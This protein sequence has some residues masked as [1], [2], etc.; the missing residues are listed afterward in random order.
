MAKKEG[1]TDRQVRH[2]KAGTKRMEV[3]AGP[4][5]GLYL[6]VHPTGRKSWM[7]RYRFRGR[8]RGLTLRE[9]YPDMSLAQARAEAQA[10]LAKLQEDIDPAA[11]HAEEA[12]QEKPDSAVAVAEEWLKRYVRPNT[13]WDEA[14]RILNRDVLPAWKD[15]LITEIGRADVLRLLD[16]IV[17]RG[18]PIVANRTFEVIRSW[19][20]WCVRRGILETSSLAGVRPPTVEKSRD[21]VLK[22]EELALV[23]SAAPD[24]DFPFGP[25]IRL[26]I[27]TAQRRGEVGQMRW[28]DVDM[29]HAMWTL[30]AEATKPGR[31]HDVPLPAVAM[32]LLEGL[33]RFENGPFIFTT[34]GGA[35]P[36]SG[37][38]KAK[39]R[40][41]AKIINGSKESLAGWTLH[42]LR[43]TAATHMAAA[44]VP[45]HVLSALL[46]HSAGSTQGVLSIYNRFRYTEERR[47]A[48]EAWGEY[49]T[50]LT[51]GRKRRAG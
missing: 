48:L 22:P 38:S 2:M 10:A 11:V 30:P 33:P 49:V 47:K 6:V 29:D 19:F 5:S 31:V 41:D 7:F 39:L 26:L 51:A 3:P 45:P 23:W 9:P 40:L 24:M 42:D 46:N 8:T 13:K 17:D 27:L 43:R 28:Q 35:K 15:K 4:P 34:T 32:K 25:F 50:G 14:E 20:N 37:W 1:L 36:I 44:E 12:Q 18:A 21:R 16:S